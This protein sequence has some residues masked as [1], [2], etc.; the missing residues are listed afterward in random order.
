MD[1]AIAIG[2][3]ALILM[4]TFWVIRMLLIPQP[5][6]PDPDAVREVAVDYR[7]IVCGLRLTITHAHD[8]DPE[9]P[10]HCREDMVEVP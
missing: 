1:L 6:D 2:I 4:F 9:P 10:R 5:A 7:C 8:S 3:G